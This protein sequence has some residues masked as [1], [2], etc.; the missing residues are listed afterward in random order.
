MSSHPCG[1][2]FSPALNREGKPTQI[3]WDPSCS[4]NLSTEEEDSG[5][6]VTVSHCLVAAAAAASFHHHHPKGAF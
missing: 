1:S 3:Q 4:P 2:C 6:S 5:C